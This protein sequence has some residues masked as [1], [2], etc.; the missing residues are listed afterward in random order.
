MVLDAFEEDPSRCRS[1]QS[2]NVIRQADRAGHA[3]NAGG[4]RRLCVLHRR[5]KS[6]EKEGH[7]EAALGRCPPTLQSLQIGGSV[8]K[9][10]RGQRTLR[11]ALRVGRVYPDELG[12][13]LQETWEASRAQHV[14]C[15]ARCSRR[16]PATQGNRV[17]QPIARRPRSKFSDSLSTPSWPSHT[18]VDGIA[19][20][21]HSASSNGK[22]RHGRINY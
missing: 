21:I 17:K 22:K 10:R 1:G 14:Q 18:R 16:G 5:G 11:S 15:Y 2:R 8:R 7:R 12:P 3:E 20:P 13:S 4:K 19:E 6:P 9:R